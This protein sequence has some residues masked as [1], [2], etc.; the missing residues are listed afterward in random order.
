M[1][2][3]K[4]ATR[5]YVY[6]PIPSAETSSTG[7]AT[8]PVV[9]PIGEPF[10]NHSYAVY[11]TALVALATVPVLLFTNVIDVGLPQIRLC[12]IVKFGLRVG[13]GNGHCE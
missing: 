4:V 6:E 5:E 3:T 2:V 1:L 9:D 12:D 7:G 10:L 8:N 11:D 13:A